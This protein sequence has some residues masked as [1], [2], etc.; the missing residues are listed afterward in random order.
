MTWKVGI[1]GAGAATS[2]EG[3]E[4]EEA[5]GGSEPYEKD[6]REACGEV[7]GEERRESKEL[8]AYAAWCAGGRYGPSEIVASAALV[9][10]KTCTGP[11]MVE[12]SDDD[13]ADERDDEGPPA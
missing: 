5:E 8:R 13:L 10:D 9:D 6:A 3:E 1:A 4:T 11:E 2:A 7:A 12:R